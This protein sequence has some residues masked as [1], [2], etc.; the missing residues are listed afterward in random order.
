VVLQLG[1]WC[2]VLKT[3]HRKNVYV[4]NRSQR[5]VRVRGEAYAWFMCGNLTERDNLKDPDVD[6]RII[7]TI[8]S[9]SGIWGHKLDRGNS[10]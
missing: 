6:G 7:L 5:H 10:E 8:S 9:G 4:T 1:G 2:E 3:L